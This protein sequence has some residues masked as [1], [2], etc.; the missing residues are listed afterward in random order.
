MDLN[1][2][3]FR[4][5]T[6]PGRT[7]IVRVPRGTGAT[8]AQRYAELPPNERVNFV[9]HRVR[10]GDTL[11]EIAQQYGVSVS[12]IRAANNNVDPR[13]LRIGLRLV[14]PVSS[15]ARSRAVGGTA[16][17]PTPTVSGVRYHTVRSG[18]SLW[19][20]S[21]RYGVSVADLR[22]WNRIDPNDN[23]VRVGDRLTVTAP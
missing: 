18:E 6:P 12:L 16:P 22:R 8:V 1:R 20:I 9:E 10:Q 19:T 15:A 21:Q 17:R 23:I 7:S 4:G 3:Y 11:S 5:V 2:H 14:I 13:R